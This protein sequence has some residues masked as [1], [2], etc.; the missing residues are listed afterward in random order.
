MLLLLRYRFDEMVEDGKTFSAEDLKNA[1]QGIASVQMT[2][3]RLYRIHNEEFALRVGVN[4][5]KHSY[6]LY[7]QY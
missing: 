7:M 2:L 6:E 5:A 1:F 3:L 4:R